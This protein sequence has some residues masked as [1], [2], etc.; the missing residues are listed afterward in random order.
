[1]NLSETAATVEEAFNK[2]LGWEVYNHDKES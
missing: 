1:M 2:Y